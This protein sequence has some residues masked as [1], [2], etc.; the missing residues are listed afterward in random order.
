MKSQEDVLKK[1]VAHAKEYGF[2]FPSSEVYDGLSAIYDYG[3]N[4]VELKNNIKQ[5][6]W[7]AMVQLNENILGLDSAI[8]MHPTIWKASG[9][10][11]AFNDPLI[12]NKDSK[13]RFRA[14][15]LVED[16]AEKFEDKAKKEIEKARK[17]F[18][19][20]FDL[21][22]FE[23]TNSK[24]LEYRKQ[25]ADILQRL[26]KSLETNLAD[27]KALIEE[28]EIGDPETGSKNWTEVRQFNLMFGT[29][30]GSTADSATDLYLRPETAQGI[31]VNYLNVQKTG[32]KKLPFGIAQIGKA[33]RNEIVARQFI[34]R[35]REFEQMEMQF[36]VPPGTELSYFKEWKEKRLNWHLA[37]GLGKDNYRFHD[38]EKL[39]HYANAATDIEF[40]F[41]FGF[42]ELEGI[43][44]RTDFDLSAHE[45]YS[46]K[47]L[48]YFD[49]EQ[50]KSYVPYVVETSIGLDRMF[51]ALLS[52]CLKDE[53]LE[54]GSS[55]VVLSLPP[56]LAP[57][58][59]AIFPLLKKDGLPEYAEKI[60]NDLKFDYNVMYEDKDA[61]GKRY[62]RQDAIGTPY[63]ITVD[64][65][66][67]SDHTVTIRN[68]DTMK[69]ER[70]S[71]D[72]LRTILGE[73]VEL[74][75][76]LKKI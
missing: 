73:N 11:D 16:F 24:V 17:R 32:R 43:H 70:V 8:F 39:A 33:F 57:N 69:Q 30:L 23:T 12:D 22:Q 31:F 50:N 61:I 26:A 59:V 37:L 51:L 3:Q 1:V 2:V 68:R 25:K 9:H 49:P 41:P 76:L 40:N 6:W 63:C 72:S 20:A 53:T 48:Q 4:G 10:V 45:K 71:V 66:T 62:R 36:F 47:K 67:L 74:K 7:K 44:S 29:K 28:L 18:G 27:T 5:Y 35:M 46:G 64:H 13:K 65:D 14:D 58:K 42:K 21:E 19:E 34:F 55:R 75:S 60:F 52:K 56:A 38:H 54:D 15:V